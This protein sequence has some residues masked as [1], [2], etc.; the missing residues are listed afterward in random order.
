MRP[1]ETG[2]SLHLLDPRDIETGRKTRAEPLASPSFAQTDV[3]ESALSNALW[4]WR[5]QRAERIDQLL[6]AH[7]LVSTPGPGRKW[8]TEQIN[9]AVI[10]RLA[11][12]FQG[13][14]RDLHDQAVDHLVSHL[15]ATSPSIA[16]VLQTS[17]TLNRALDKVNAQPSS[18]GA[19]FQRLGMSF[20]SA[21]K[22]EFPAKATI[23][24]DTLEQLNKAR[25]G[26]AHHD[27]SKLNEVHIAGWPT[28]QVATAQRFRTRLEQLVDGMDKVV[29]RHLQ[30]LTGGPAPW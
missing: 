1:R 9:A 10:V 4:E 12:E 3:V 11:I 21:L 28:T 2:A 5:G 30:S 16:P 20:W 13:F 22:T 19:D 7:R 18:L 25:N 17:L 6:E 24:N 8:R 23:W 14:S 27:T 15:A 29:S 26:I